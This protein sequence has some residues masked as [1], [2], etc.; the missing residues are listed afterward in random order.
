MSHGIE[1]QLEFFGTLSTFQNR[2]TPVLFILPGTMVGFVIIALLVLNPFING[3]VTWH[4]PTLFLS[5]KLNTKKVSC[6]WLAVIY[7][8]LYFQIQT[9]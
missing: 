1:I 7:H 4:R 9:I 3:Y 2:L 8:I 6:T 5:S